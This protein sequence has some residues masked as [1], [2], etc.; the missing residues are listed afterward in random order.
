MTAGENA[1][2]E[3]GY[4]VDSLMAAVYSILGGKTFE[5]TI[6]TAINLGYDTDTNAAITG[7]L[8]G[9]FYG[10]ESIPERWLNAMRRL[11]YLEDVAERFAEVMIM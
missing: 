6:L 10:I 11:D 7:A 8:A 1:I 9:A 4:V 2:G 5:D 3:T